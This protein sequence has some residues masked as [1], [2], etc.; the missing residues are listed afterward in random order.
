VLL[1]KLIAGHKPYAHFANATEAEKKKEAIVL[2]VV[3]TLGVYESHK[4]SY[5]AK[6]LNC[7]FVLWDERSRV[8]DIAPGMDMSQNACAAHPSVVDVPCYV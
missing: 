2:L 4:T 6:K 3:H 7:K 8:D 1:A 5:I